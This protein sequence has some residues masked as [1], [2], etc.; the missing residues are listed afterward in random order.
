[1]SPLKPQD[2]AVALQVLLTP[3]ATYAALA[4]ATGLSQGGVHH[5]VRRLRG[6]R[7]VLADALQVHRAALLAFLGSGVAYAFPAEAGAD[8]RSVPAAHSAG[9]LAAEFVASK[10][11][12]W[13]SI[14]GDVRGA[15]VVPL[16]AA[17]PT[18]ATRNPKLYRL[19]V[20]RRCRTPRARL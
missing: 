2:I 10:P 17:A 3:G 6:A 9:E 7:L 15:S 16:Y 19:L 11:L 8:S 13:P 1:M 14:A 4:M 5:A 20:H 12:V 18:T